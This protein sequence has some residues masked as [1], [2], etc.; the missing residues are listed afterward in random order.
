MDLEK[1]DFEPETILYEICELIRPKLK[2]KPVEIICRVGDDIPRILN[3][4][5]VRF[6]QV[7]INLMGNAAKFTESGEIELSMGLAEKRDDSVKLQASVRDTGIGISKEEISLIFEAFRQGD[8]FSARKYEGTGL[9]L[10]ICKQIAD[11]MN[12][13][14]S[15][16]STPGSGSVFHFSAWFQKGQGEGIGDLVPLAFVKSSKVLIADDNPSNLEILAHALSRSGLHV[17]T[18]SD[19]ADILP[20]LLAADAAKEPYGLAMI[21]IHMPHM[22]GYEAAAQIRAHNSGISRTPLLALSCSMDESKR[23]RKKGFDG[24]LIKPAPRHK[25]IKLV[26]RLMGANGAAKSANGTEVEM[27]PQP[28]EPVLK[29]IRILLAEDNPVNLKLAKIILS[30][31]GFRVVDSAANGHEAV[32]KYTASPE[33]FDLILMDVQM[34]MMDGLGATK[35]IRDK[36]FDKVPIVAMTANAL[37]DDREK[38]LEAGMNDYIAKPINRETVLE[39]IRR[40]V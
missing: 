2:D 16:E 11:L 37:K 14:L 3:G 10:A 35:A 29:P 15:V 32:A 25:L 39:V 24:F 1:V 30:K 20:A 21:D 34:P 18:F 23:S 4:D 38:C 31:S 36:G 12:G 28:S 7:L 33:S 19:S 9:G 13:E 40:W 22:S 17:L 27:D 5:Q 6:R 26:S 8:D